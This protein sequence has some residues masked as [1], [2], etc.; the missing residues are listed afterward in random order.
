MQGYRTAAPPLREVL[1]ETETAERTARAGGLVLPVFRGVTRADATLQLVMD[2]S[3]SMR[4]WDRMFAELEQVFSGLGAFRDIQ[5]SH[6][7]QGPD[8]EPAVSRSPEPGA[9]PCTP[10]TG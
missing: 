7:H 4:V 2:A 6:L 3:S 5:V 10:P 1:D 9:A 8:G